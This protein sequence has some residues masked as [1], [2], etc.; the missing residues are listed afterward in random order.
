[1]PISLVDNITFMPGGNSDLTLTQ[2]PV[3][4]IDSGISV[5]AHWRKCS[6][7]EI[8]PFTPTILSTKAEHSSSRI[9]FGCTLALS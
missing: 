1:M 8:G 9:F 6:A 3:D 4:I 2:G 7:S 5:C